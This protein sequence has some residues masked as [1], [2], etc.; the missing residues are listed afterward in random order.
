[1]FAE[2][3]ENRQVYIDGLLT[4]FNPENLN[5]KDVLMLV[6]QYMSQRP[7]G[8]ARQAFI[9]KLCKGKLEVEGYLE[10]LPMYEKLGLELQIQCHRN[11]KK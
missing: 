3:G 6:R 2:A 11:E 5:T 9:E 1:M 10:K 8:E 7:N 4:E